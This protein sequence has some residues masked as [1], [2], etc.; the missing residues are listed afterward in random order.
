MDQGVPFPKSTLISCGDAT[1]E[2]LIDP[3]PRPAPPP[4][5]VQTRPRQRRVVL[6]DHRKP[7][8][9]IILGRAKQILEEQGIEAV[10]KEKPAAGSPMPSELVE[11]LSSEQG[12][13]LCGISDC[14]SCSASSAVDS[15][16]LQHRGVAGFAILTEP[17]QKQIDR[18]MAYQTADRVLPAIILPHPMQ[19][20]D[21]AAIELRAR[22]LADM[23]V[24]LLD[25]GAI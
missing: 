24:S 17:F 19:N 14:G 22:T 3:I 11:E 16:V 6:V 2:F 4:L 7:N 5:A 18:A 9:G 21:A 15:V 20:I 12:L 25:T 8:S 13:V 23:A 10:L 1:C